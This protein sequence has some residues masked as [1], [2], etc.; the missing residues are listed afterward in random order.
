M[1]EL[2][3]VPFLACLVL[4]AM[5]VYLGLHVLARGI[6]FVDLALAQL[7]ALGMAAALL[8]GHAVQSDA[9]YGYALAFTMAGAVFFALSRGRRDTAVPQEAV[10]GIVYA[11][12]AAVAILILD[13]APQGSEHIKQLLMG[14]ILTVTP[15]EVATLALLYA[16]LGV[17][18]GLARKPLLEISS[19]PEAARRRGRRVLAW[20]LFFY[21][22]FGLVVTSS[23]RVA[24]VLLVFCFLVVPAAISALLVGSLAARL[25]LGWAVGATVSALGLWAS[26]HWDLPTGAAVVAAFGAAFALVGLLLATRLAAMRVR[27]QGLRGL[28][29]AGAAASAAVAL[30]GLLLAAFP[31][32][33]HHWLDW[34]ESRVPA[35]RA[36]FLDADDRAAYAGAREDTE[37]GMAELARLR[38]TQQDVQWGRQQMS[39]VMQERLRQYLAGRGEIVAGDHRVM[40]NL[41]L[42]AREHQRWSLGLPLALVGA[43][44]A[45]LLLRARRR[46]GRRA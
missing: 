1:L 5:H 8:A 18:H 29:G 35:L 42:G 12:G 45:A 43:A 14:G 20:D 34:S 19:D 3:A 11:V 13:R 32:M 46:S 16:G 40:A 22:S 9:A 30:A 10:I 31:G 21:A 2:L 44:A 39:D 6:I 27:A 17:A 37:R 15:G 25:A 26:Y 36:L 24:G 38:A 4:A 33:D 28:A 23:V 41:Q 7:A